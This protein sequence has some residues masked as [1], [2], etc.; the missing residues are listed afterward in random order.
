MKDF[1]HLRSFEG[2]FN[3]LKEEHNT[4]SHAYPEIGF[5]W[6]KT[7]WGV[8]ICHVFFYTEFMGERMVDYKGLGGMIERIDWIGPF[9][10]EWRA[11]FYSPIK[12]L[13]IDSETTNK[14]GRHKSK[15][16]AKNTIMI[17]L[18]FALNK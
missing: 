13:G 2:Y 5:Q 16:E 8:E 17:A 4:S 12:Q 1:E 7:V 11:E 3:H 15:Q 10:P 18:R 6:A 14:L 9:I